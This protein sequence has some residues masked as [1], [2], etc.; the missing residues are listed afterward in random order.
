MWRPIAFFTMIAVSFGLRTGWCFLRV[1]NNGFLEHTLNRLALLAFFACVVCRV[2]VAARLVA[3]ITAAMAVLPCRAFAIYVLGWAEMLDS[4]WMPKLN[5]IALVFNIVFSVAIVASSVVAE[6]LSGRLLRFHCI[7][8]V[9]S[10]MQAF[11]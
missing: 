5:R 3:Y 9:G 10:H 11:P 4:E 6:L 8:C 1:M 2:R 7:G